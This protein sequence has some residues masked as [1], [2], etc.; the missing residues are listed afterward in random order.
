M[1]CVD[2]VSGVYFGDIAF[3]QNSIDFVLE[4]IPD[5]LLFI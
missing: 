2:Y 1:W 5:K 4:Y 3:S